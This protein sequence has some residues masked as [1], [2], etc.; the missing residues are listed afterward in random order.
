M[1]QITYGI[2]D[3][4][5]KILYRSQR[6]QAR[7]LC[8][9]QNVDLDRIRQIEFVVY[10]DVYRLDLKISPS[11]KKALEKAPPDLAQQVDVIFQK[12][13][14]PKESESDVKAKSHLTAGLEFCSH[15]V[16]L[17]P[18]GKYLKDLASIDAVRC[19]ED[20]GEISLGKE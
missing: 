1:A 20:V 4:G 12:N 16:R 10:V 7:H 14:D 18:E 5:A 3:A 17:T 13:K 2:G 6:K 11:L 15:K 9:Y 8:S 19:I